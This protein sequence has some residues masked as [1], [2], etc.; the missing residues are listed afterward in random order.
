MHYIGKIEDEWQ[1]SKTTLAGFG[2][3]LSGYGV[4]IA[5]LTWFEFTLS[6]PFASTAVVT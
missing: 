6:T 3:T 1:S 2:G 4:G 5:V